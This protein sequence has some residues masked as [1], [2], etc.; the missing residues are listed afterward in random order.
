[1]Y[2]CDLLWILGIM[3][4]A[5]FGFIVT[6]SR[7]F[8]RHLS[9]IHIQLHYVTSELQ[10]GLLIFYSKK[11]G[12]KA[13]TSQGYKSCTM[14]C[15]RDFKGK[16]F[17][18][19]F[20]DDNYIRRTFVQ[21]FIMKKICENENWSVHVDECGRCQRRYVSLTNNILQQF[22]YSVRFWE[23]KNSTGICISAQ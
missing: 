2:G 21:I 14:A 10:L 15:T 11:F 22:E 23:V 3:F 12:L 6:S 5:S 20:C 8:S 18:L 9:C 19:V 16:L 17:Q 1:M 7:C 4:F 13:F